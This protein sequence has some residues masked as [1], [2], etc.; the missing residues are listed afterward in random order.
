MRYLCVVE[1]DGTNYAGWQIQPNALSIQEVI[2]E[3]LSKILNTPTKIYGS[4]R[5]LYF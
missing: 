4:G 3:R 2:E 5:N 1:Y